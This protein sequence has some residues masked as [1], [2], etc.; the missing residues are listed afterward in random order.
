MPWVF[1]ST[2]GAVNATVPASSSGGTATGELVTLPNSGSLTAATAITSAQFQSLNLT[3]LGANAVNGL[4]VDPTHN[5]GVAFSFNDNV[6]SF[7][8]LTSYNQVGSYT[9][10]TS[11][12][13]AMNFS[14]AFPTIGGIVMDS[15]KQ[16]AIFST[17]AGFEIVSYS[18]PSSPAKLRLI[19]GSTANTSNVPGSINITENFGYDPSLS[20][21]GTTHAMILAGGYTSFEMADA[22]S[23]TIYE[24]D[25]S[26]TSILSGLSSCGVDQIG[27][28]TS[29]QVA[30]LGCEDNGNGYLIN[31]NKLT[32]NASA[33]TYTLPSSAVYQFVLPSYEMDNVAVESANHLVFIGSGGYSGGNSFFIGQLSDPSSSLGFSKSS[34]GSTAVAMPVYSTSNTK[35]CTVSGCTPLAVGTT[36]AGWTDPHSNGA[37]LD[38]NNNSVVLWENLSQN[39]IAIV[40]LSSVITNPTAPPSGSIWYQGIP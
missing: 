25:S 3:A 24:P 28:D 14:G 17:G 7:F 19:S 5:L 9:C 35:S 34:G 11:C 15:T 30:V 13:T 36:W 21:G 27:V 38:Q 2:N 22:N 10:T 40:N 32:L 33:G 4:N 37:F 29:Y 6:L 12:A 23:G 8:S 1:T 20:V 31:L 18:S 16:W 39:A 26:T